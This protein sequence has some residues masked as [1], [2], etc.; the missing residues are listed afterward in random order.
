LLVF[1]VFAGG[2]GALSNG[3]G[4]GWAYSRDIMTSNPGDA[5]SDY[6]ILVSV[7]GQR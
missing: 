4:G 3:G 1:L 2:A 5:L 6:Q 7:S